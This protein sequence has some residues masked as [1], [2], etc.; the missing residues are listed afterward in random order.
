MDR[1]D[2][3]FSFGNRGA[4]SEPQH[5]SVPAMMWVSGADGSRTFLSKDWYELTGQSAGSGLG[6]GWMDAVHP[7]DRAVAEEIVTMTT[8]GRKSF[9]L[10]YRLRRRDGSWRWVLDGAAPWCDAAG[11]FLGFLGSVVDI[12]HWKQAELRLHEDEA[13]LLSTLAHELR[14][15]LA[16]I[17]N[18]VSILREKGSLD[19]DVQWCREIIERQVE[20]LVHLLEE[21]LDASWLTHGELRTRIESLERARAIAAPARPVDREA[22]RGVARANRRILVVD[23]NHDGADSLAML[24]GFLGHDVRTAYDGEEAVAAAEEFRPQIILLD[25]EM[26]KLN[27]YEACRRIRQRPWARNVVVVACTGW[28]QDEDRRRAREAGFNHHIVK[29]VDTGVLQT[30]ISSAGRSPTRHS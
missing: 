1:P 17:R 25:V 30:V 4:G 10:Q 8:Q 16:P 27:G 20:Q 13:R 29:P 22:D 28:G 18:A 24:L 5:D 19:P 9:H 14:N 26:P 6:R 2:A 15:P 11:E 3:G 7:D 21:L 12:T 23:D